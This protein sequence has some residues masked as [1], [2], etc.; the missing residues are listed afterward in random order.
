M[1]AGPNQYAFERPD[2][3]N[4]LFTYAVSEGIA[5]AAL[6]EGQR[7]LRVRDLGTYVA[8]R[9]FSLS[10]GEQDPRFTPHANFVLA[11]R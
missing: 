6:D 8:K 10:R 1:A 11:H 9:V 4:G 5:G 2:I 3:A 7:L